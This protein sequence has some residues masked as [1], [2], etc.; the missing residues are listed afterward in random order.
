MTAADHIKGLYEAKRLD[1]WQILSNGIPCLVTYTP[2][3][4]VYGALYDLKK[5]MD[6]R[7]YDLR[8]DMDARFS[9]LDS[10]LDSKFV[11]LQAIMIFGFVSI[12]LMMKKN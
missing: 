6:A 12:A 4:N 7:F 11:I 1:E 10:K 2:H 8:K 3:R 9:S 5:D